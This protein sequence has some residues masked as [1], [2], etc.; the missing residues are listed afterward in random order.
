MI[1]GV[2]F[3][4][5]PGVGARYGSDAGDAGQ[6]LHDEHGTHPADPLAGR[7]RVARQVLS[8]PARPIRLLALHTPGRESFTG[9]PVPQPPPTAEALVAPSPF[10]RRRARLPGR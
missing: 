4:R 10:F 3:S 6:A 8:E 7:N 5:M 9:H 1:E 2:I